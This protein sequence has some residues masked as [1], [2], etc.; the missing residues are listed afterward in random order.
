MKTFVPLWTVALTVIEIVCARAG[1]AVRPQTY[2]CETAAGVTYADRPC[3]PSSQPILL[4]AEAINTYHPPP[5][6]H[7]A[8]R[9]V[10]EKPKPSRE[11]ASAERAAAK[12]AEECRKI[13][14]SLGDIRERMRTGYDVATGEKLRQTE[15]KLQARAR[16]DKC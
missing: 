8:L 13:A 2:R 4:D 1:E 5:E 11:S 7:T 10:K 9:T 12:K 3:G 14:A 16:E 15:R 6:T